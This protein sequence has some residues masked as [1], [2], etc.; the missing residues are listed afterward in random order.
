MFPVAA[1]LRCRPAREEDQE[2]MTD[3]VG[4]QRDDSSPNVDRYFNSYAQMSE[5]IATLQRFMSLRDMVIRVLKKKSEEIADLEI[6]DIGCGA[7]TQC[8]LWAQNGH[9]HVHGIDINEGLIKLGKQ[10]AAVGG[11]TIDFCL[12]SSADLPWSDETMDVCLV[13]EVL[14]HVPAWQTCLKEY[15]RILRP[16]GLLLITTS[17][18][19]CPLQ[20]EFRLPLYSWYPRW[21]KKYCEHLA[22]TTHPHLVNYSRYPAVNWFS[23]YML[24]EELQKLGFGLCLDRFDV[25]DTT[26]KGALA[27]VVLQ[28]MRAVPLLR[29]LGHVT[30]VGTLIVAFK[31]DHRSGVNEQVTIY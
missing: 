9:R 28:G 16:G 18:K 29:W 4:K 13:P 27:K 1:T 2:S 22:V 17:N 8:I 31:A 19:L 20:E 26:Q 5:S 6:A 30:N 11:H 10:R 7:G 21:V 12:G 23:Y 24:R 15:A 14:E 3:V 25:I